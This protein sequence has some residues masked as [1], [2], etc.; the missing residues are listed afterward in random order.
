MVGAS[1]AGGPPVQ[2]ATNHRSWQ[3][4]AAAGAGTPFN[5]STLVSQKPPRPRWPWIAGGAVIVVAAVA[6]VVAVAAGT[7]SSPA[8]QG[9]G[10][11]KTYSDFTNECGLVSPDLLTQYAP[12]ARCSSSEF[13]RTSADAYTRSPS[14]IVENPAK[15]PASIRL[16]LTLATKA[17][18]IFDR[19]K[20]STL[21][22]FPVTD[23]IK[24][25]GPFALG[26]E[27]HLLS[28]TSRITP[29]QFDGRV[30]LRSGNLVIDV[31]YNNFD[32]VDE[33][34]AGVQAICTEILRNLH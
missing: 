14:W 33:A 11:T 6:G 1:P 15:P 5:T 16:S 3:Q 17:P 22:T 19:T 20:Q 12:G 29:G 7:S 30:I 4:P 9:A 26:D 2:S 32:G 28:G 31:T 13:P 24:T 8:D 21:K 10:P 34:E 18:T 27:A 23:T 25:S